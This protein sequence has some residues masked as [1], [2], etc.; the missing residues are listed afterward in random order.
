MSAI[1]VQ[2]LVDALNPA[3]LS[4]TPNRFTIRVGE[5]TLDC[6]FE[7]DSLCAEL[8][9][10]FGHVISDCE[11][12][13]MTVHVFGEAVLPF[14]VDYKDWAREPGKTGRK[15][16]IADL[17]DGRMVFKVRT[18]VTF[19]QSATWRLAFGP[20]S[21]HPNQVINFINTQI[22]NHY[23]RVGWVGCH[24]AAVACETRTLAIAGL[25]GG[26]K[27]TTMLRLM[28][29]DGASYV[30]NDRLLVGADA[31]LPKALGIPKLP[32]INP[33]TI[34]TNPRLK[35][36]LS[37]ERTDTLLSMPQE[38][39]WQLEEK[40][41]LFVD[42]VYGPNR[43]A[44]QTALTDFWVLNWSRETDEPTQFI[45]VNIAERPDLLSAI[46]KNPGPFYCK[47]DGIFWTDDEH[48]DAAGYIAA[49]KGVKIQEVSG[50]IDF[51]AVYAAGA[52]LLKAPE[53][54]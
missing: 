43:I 32:R 46:M 8:R 19:L 30:T 12:A 16:A 42:E 15:D 27:S 18:G 45:E 51:E 39:L 52:R 53:P 37:S 50:K 6:L 24:A 34:V 11:S 9:R 31:P 36:M 22:L 25:S 1:T 40:Y 4:E 41:D 48:V 33:G 26:G 47:P 21:A 7:N 14:H 17:E 13:D 20:T 2:D 54:V 35:G 29:L 44:H 10:Y 3:S 38:E 5:L 28:D 23:Q 49:L